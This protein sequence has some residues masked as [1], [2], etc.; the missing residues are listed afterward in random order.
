MADMTE[1]T[2]SQT[3]LKSALSGIASLA[4]LSQTFASAWMSR[5][6]RRPIRQLP[7]VKLCITN[8]CNS[9]CLACDL[10]QNPG[11]CG[12]EL[13][14]AEIQDMLPAMR[15][16]KVR[17]LSIGGGEPTLRDDLEDCI[18]WFSQAG[19]SVHMVTNGLLIDE[20]RARSLAQAGL[21]AVHLSCDHVDPAGY[22][23]V[24]GVDGYDRAV[25]A[26]KLLRSLPRPIPVGVNV[27]LS[28]RNM[29]VIEAFV[30]RA[31]EWGVQKLQFI[32]I[33]THLQHREMAR[34]A[35][36]GLIPTARDL[37][38]IKQ[39]LERST[40]RLWDLGIESN[41]SCY[42][43]HYDWAYVEGRTIPCTA[44]VLYAQITS[45]G[46]VLPCYELPTGLSVRQM[47]LDRIVASPRYRALLREA[48]R[49]RRA[50]WDVGSAEPDI[51][52]HLPYLLGHPFESYRQWR[53][54]RR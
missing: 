15:R 48:A 49:C 40:R 24:R 53:L 5:F 36:E 29:D 19:I 52:F 9:R 17:M 28:R 34:S 6:L 21:A 31:V 44:G 8:R 26:M 27:V 7:L 43:G 41:S 54:Y 25:R 47:S 46:E 12:D 39:A 51:R 45:S 37:E 11:P 20:A 13:T 35:F 30:D 32:P 50:C 18:A 23:G 2:P 3:R 4:Q 42:C 10:W 22:K 1:P 38:A 14:T 33:H 16:L